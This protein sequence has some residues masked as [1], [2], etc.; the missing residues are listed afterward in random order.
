MKRLLIFLLFTPLSILTVFGQNSTPKS[1]FFDTDKTV[2]RTDAQAILRNL[3][4]SARKIPKFTL[5]LQSNTDADGSDTYNQNLS[6]RRT[7]AVRQFLIKEGI[8]ADKIRISALGESQPISENSSDNGKQRNRRV[9]ISFES[10]TANKT[11]ANKQSPFEKGKSYHIMRLYKEL[12]LTPQIFTIKSNK[13]TT[14]RGEKG[15]LLHFPNDAF[16]GVAP[17]TPIE[18]KLKECYDYASIIAEHLTTKS[19]DNLLQTGGMIYVQ[20]MANGKELTLQKPMEIQF[21]SAE[22]KLKGMQLF[23]GERKMDRN[24]AMNWTP[25]NEIRDSPFNPPME[26]DSGD[27]IGKT[28]KN[29]DNVYLNYYLNE[30]SAPM[31]YIMDLTDTDSLFAEFPVYGKVVNPKVKY[32]P[33][34]ES[35]TGNSMGVYACQYTEFIKTDKLILHRAAFNDVYKFYK[36]ETY[37]ALQKQDTSLWNKIYREKTA[38]LQAA[39]IQAIKDLKKIRE[40]GVMTG[41]VF[42]AAKLHYINCD[43]FTDYPQNQLIS[44]YA[45]DKGT[46]AYDAKLILKKDKVV[47]EGFITTNNK[48]EFGSVVKNVDA[49]IV[50]M[51]IENGQSYL[52]MHDF[53]T[54]T[55]PIDL[56]FEALSPEEIKEK[57]KKLN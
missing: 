13:D 39:K 9:D 23:S 49:V 17:N 22:S 34:S 36:V 37:A 56:K 51:K 52:A 18:I 8:A 6:E 19:G 3:A 41:Q 32:Y 2:L 27:N 1:V 46:Y 29:A 26:T 25:I 24:G 14:I 5:R 45:N 20:A 31:S 15:T 40:I 54:S 50:A 28:Y 16:A 48:I 53:I 57:L 11:I 10:A 12:S 4:D 35:F 30:T 55:T 43:R 47:L 44:F 7:D 21:S 42:R 38:K 33:R